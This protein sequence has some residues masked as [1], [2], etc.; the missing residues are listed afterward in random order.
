MAPLT[1][2]L[3][4]YL[5]ALAVCGVLV[6]CILGIANVKTRRQELLGIPLSLSPASA[7]ET[8]NCCAFAGCPCCQPAMKGKSNTLAQTSKA[9]L[10]K[11][12]MLA[13]AGTD[14]AALS[15][16]EVTVVGAFA[17]DPTRALDFRLHRV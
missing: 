14:A 3:L 9:K 1:R 6:G 15:S 8:C 11:Q 12:T 10:V 4:P 7:T 13:G 5:A 2:G 16:D 17:P